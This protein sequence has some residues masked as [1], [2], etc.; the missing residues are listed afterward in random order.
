[1]RWIWSLHF[2]PLLNKNLHSLSV[3]RTMIKHSFRCIFLHSGRGLQS[4]GVEPSIFRLWVWRG[5]PFHSP[6]YNAAPETRTQTPHKRLLSIFKT[7]PLPIRVNAAYCLLVQNTH[8][9]GRQNNCYVN[10]YIK[11]SKPRAYLHINQCHLDLYWD[12]FLCATDWRSAQHF[13]W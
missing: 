13:G 4:L 10:S 2:H 11:R 3:I 7:D 12:R 5:N 9:Q 8:P 1:M 6:A